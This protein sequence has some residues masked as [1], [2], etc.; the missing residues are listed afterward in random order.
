MSTKTKKA[1]LPKH[2]PDGFLLLTRVYGNKKTKT[3]N[4][5][6]AVEDVSTVRAR[7]KKGLEGHRATIV[8]KGRKYINVAQTFVEVWKLIC[9]NT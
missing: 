5:L 7:N 2:A 1:V 9:D 3:Q 8:T 4:M 6:L